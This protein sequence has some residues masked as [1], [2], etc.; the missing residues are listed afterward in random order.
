M[1]THQPTESH[2]GHN[3]GSPAH[4]THLAASHD[5]PAAAN[6]RTDG[7]A[8]SAPSAVITA[9]TPA[10]ANQQGHAMHVDHTGHEL[11]FCN[12][13][14]GCA[15]PTIPVLLYSNMHQR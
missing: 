3:T 6:G 7:H 8:H 11:Q 5:K 14:S 15:I 13:F 4:H 1:T 2:D 10:P 12:R 9:A